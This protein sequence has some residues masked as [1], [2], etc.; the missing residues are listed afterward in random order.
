MRAGRVVMLAMAVLSFVTS[1]FGVFAVVY[2]AVYMR[3]LRLK[4][5]PD[6][7]NPRHLLT[8][9]GHYGRTEPSGQRFIH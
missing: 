3:R 6:P 7:D 4:I 1:I 8:I 5:E 2:V 9:R